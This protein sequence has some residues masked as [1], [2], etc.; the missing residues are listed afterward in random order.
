MR[1]VSTSGNWTIGYHEPISFAPY[2][3]IYGQVSDVNPWMNLDDSLDV[4]FTSTYDP[5]VM[6]RQIRRT[7]AAL[8]R[9]G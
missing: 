5:D 2:P 3:A 8:R 1:T 4:T 9:N 7:A 6:T